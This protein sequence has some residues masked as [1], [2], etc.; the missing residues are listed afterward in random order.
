MRSRLSAEGWTIPAGNGQILPLVIGSDQQ[1][2]DSQMRLEKAGLLS[3]AI[4]PPTVPEGTSRLRI[5]LRRDLPNG[6]L[7]RLINALEVK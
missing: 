3:V 7:K 4:R 6:T 2:L 1:S 5:V